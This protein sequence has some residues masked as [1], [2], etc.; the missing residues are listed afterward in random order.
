MID[1]WEK[2]EK[3]QFSNSFYWILVNNK[4]NIIDFHNWLYVAHREG[5][6]INRMF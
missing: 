4:R 6:T 1:P 2:T 3:V 5:K